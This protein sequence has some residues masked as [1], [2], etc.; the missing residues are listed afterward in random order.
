MLAERQGVPAAAAAATGNLRK[1]AAESGT[2]FLSYWLAPSRR[3][4]GLSRPRVQLFP[5]PP[6]G[7]RG[8]RPAAPGRHR[9]PYRGSLS[10]A[11]RAGYRLFEILVQPALPALP[12]GSRVLIVPDASLYALNFETLPAPGSV[13]GPPTADCRLQGRHSLIEDFGI[14]VAPS[15]AMLN[16]RPSPPPPSRR[17]LLLIGNAIARAPEYPGLKFAGAEMASVAQIPL[18]PRDILRRRARR[19]RRVPRGHA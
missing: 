14:A 13:C 15:L 2:V 18:R 9:R 4:C 8:A 10:S 5:L 7:N 6:A 17:S 16:T 11:G 19:A 1:R 12:H 3:T